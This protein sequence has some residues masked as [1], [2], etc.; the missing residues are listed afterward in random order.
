M[1]E[2]C[3]GFFTPNSAGTVHHDILLLFALQQV[4]YQLNFF[5]KGIHI[6]RDGAFEVTDFTLIM[7]AHVDEDGI[8]FCRQGIEPFR[9]QMHPRIPNIKSRIV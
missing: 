2:P 4:L 9:I 1:F 3:G 5:A 6:W 7:V 8:F